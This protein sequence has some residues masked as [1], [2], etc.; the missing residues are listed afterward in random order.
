MHKKNQIKTQKK[1]S[2][3]LVFILLLNFLIPQIS[4]ANEIKKYSEYILYEDNDV[5]ISMDV[6]SEKDIEYINKLENNLPFKLSK[7]EEF[8][9][10]GQQKR[11]KSLIYNR[12]LRT[13]STSSTHKG[14]HVLSYNRLYKSGIIKEF[15]KAKGKNF[16]KS[17]FYPTASIAT[18]SK[19]IS[20]L[21]YPTIG[22][23]IGA[24]LGALFGYA[25][26]TQSKWWDETMV[27]LIKNQI[28]YL[29]RYIC[30]NTGD[31]PKVLKF[32]YRVK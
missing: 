13:Y 25:Q 10:I 3:I 30:Q 18:I 12:N 2:Y 11:E 26:Y 15:E 6:T 7:I 19:G 16:I 24:I 22:Y 21:G 1:I 27:M 17:Y 9:E 14:Y 20:L 5:I 8:K 29:E 4:N 31:Y 28:K 23:V 32:V